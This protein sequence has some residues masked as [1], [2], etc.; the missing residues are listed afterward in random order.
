MTMRNVMGGL[1][2]AMALGAVLTSVLRR[3]FTKDEWHTVLL[4]TT[5]LLDNSWWKRY[6]R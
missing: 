4:E 6:T 1:V 2:A 3:R 5:A